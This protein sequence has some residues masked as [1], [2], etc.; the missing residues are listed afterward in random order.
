M[1]NL[2]FSLPFGKSIKI[3]DINWCEKYNLL[4]YK[5]E[6]Y[7]CGRAHDRGTKVIHT[8]LKLENGESFRTCEMAFC[9]DCQKFV[10]REFGGVDHDRT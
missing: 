6:C 1:F 7:S 3:T 8:F 9:K 4:P 2:P 10:I 5:N